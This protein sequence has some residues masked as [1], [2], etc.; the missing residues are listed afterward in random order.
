VTSILSEAFARRL[1]LQKDEGTHTRARP[2]I[3]FVAA[4][5]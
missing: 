1:R 3:H 5:P 4:I 2:A